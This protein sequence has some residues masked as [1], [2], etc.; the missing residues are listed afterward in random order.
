MKRHLR[1]NIRHNGTAGFTL[2]E[3]LVVIAIIGIL[4][5]MLLPAVQSARESARRTDCASKIRQLGLACTMYANN[6]SDQIMEGIT[7]I[8][9]DGTVLN[10]SGLTALLP[11]L[12][13]QVLY[14]NYDYSVASTA[15]GTNAV[16]PLTNV[17]GVKV[18]IFICS[19]DNKNNTG[20]DNDPSFFRSNYAQNF[21]SDTIDATGLDAFGNNARGPFRVDAAGSIASMTVDG[22]TNTALYSEVF[23]GGADSECGLWGYGAVCAN[24]YTHS[25]QPSG[26]GDGGSYVA[27]ASGSCSASAM[28]PGGVNV[29]FAG[30]SVSF[31]NENI[32]S[33]RWAAY[34][35][36][37]G[38]EAFFA[39]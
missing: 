10:H 6:N 13:A 19:S 15:Q 11:F 27:G 39:Q 24:S 38:G 16:S 7:T 28:H 18:P 17:V 32:D 3:L 5:A 4:V 20:P 31:I 29:C 33:E 36:A 23:S 21:G 2:V 14:K 1:H 37:S 34:G 26:N 8:A 30:T 22:L 12:E 25:T 35:T 9:E